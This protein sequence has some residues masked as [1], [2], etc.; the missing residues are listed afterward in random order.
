MINTNFF[1]IETHLQSPEEVVAELNASMF[2]KFAEEG[3]LDQSEK[4]YSDQLKNINDSVNGP[5]EQQQKP[6][7]GEDQKNGSQ[8]G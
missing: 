4:V 5:Q 2:A 1:Q 6:P 8:A 7:E 3:P